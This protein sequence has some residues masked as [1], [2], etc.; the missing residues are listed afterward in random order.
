M[1][2]EFK[3]LIDW[4][5]FSSSAHNKQMDFPNIFCVYLAV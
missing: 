3:N 2:L 5:I 1:E 4:L